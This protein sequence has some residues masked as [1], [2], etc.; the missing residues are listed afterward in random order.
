MRGML[1]L[2]SDFLGPA[3]FPAYLVFA[4]VLVCTEG[5]SSKER[6]DVRASLLLISKASFG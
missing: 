3:A 1:Q 2:G 4:S 6:Q 5:Y